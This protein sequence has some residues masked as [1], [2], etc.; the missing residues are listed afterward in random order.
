MHNTIAD[1]LQTA[2][3]R[4]WE[5]LNL[6]DAQEIESSRLPGGWTPKALLAHVAFWD[7][8]QRRRM[9]A[10]LQG[11]SAQT[12]FALPPTD[13]DA[14]AQADVDR[15]WEEVVAAADQARQALIAFAGSLDQT[16]LAQEYPEGTSTLS[17][18]N[19]LE[20]MVRHP[21]SHASEV[22]TYAGSMDRW[23]RPALRTFLFR[24]HN[25][26]MDG[27]SRLTEETILTTQVC[28]TWSIRDV[29]AHVL[30]WNEFTYLVISGWPTVAPEKIAAWQGDDGIDAING[31]LLA[32]RANLH[33]IDICDGLMT[34]HR[35]ILRA[36]DRASDEQL[37]SMSAHS[38]RK[39]SSLSAFFYRAALHEA[40][41]AEDIWRF[42]A[43]E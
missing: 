25:N 34:Y 15:P 5:N 6:L 12:G 31:R 21:Q 33:M 42:R 43:G 27:I 9:E 36:F 3:D 20:Q 41:H 30:S 4:L 40:R 26:L 28:G 19:L 10:A 1:R 24:Q 13:N 14:R 37:R 7:E 16:A 22:A 39:E 17:L 23:S 11:S 2:Y 8:Y 18:A 35:R 29:L 38:W 32:E